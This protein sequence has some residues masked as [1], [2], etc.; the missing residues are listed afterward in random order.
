MEHELK[1]RLRHIDNQTWI[2]EDTLKL[3]QVCDEDNGDITFVTTDENG[4]LQPLRRRR[5]DVVFRVAGLP[6]AVF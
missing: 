3:G 6:Q 2:D 5:R 4:D 1:L